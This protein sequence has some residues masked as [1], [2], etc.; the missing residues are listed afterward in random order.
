MRYTL[1]SPAF[2]FLYPEYG[3]GREKRRLLEQQSEELPL[4]LPQQQ[5]PRQPQQQHRFSCLLLQSQHSSNASN[6]W[7]E[8]ADGNLSGV[9]QKSPDLLRRYPLRYPKIKPGQLAW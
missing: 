5:Q 1:L 9:P 3:V 6:G 7:S 8:L 4:R 2:S